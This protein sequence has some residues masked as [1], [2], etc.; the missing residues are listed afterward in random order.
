MSICLNADVRRIFQLLTVAE[1][2]ETWM[3]FPGG[4][5]DAQVTAFRHQDEYR[6][7]Y[8]CDGRQH[9]SISGSYRVCRQRKVLFSW[10][11]PGLSS[12]VSLVDIRLRGNFGSSI[13]E[14]RHTGLSSAVEYFW[15]MAMWRASL[16]RLVRLTK[17]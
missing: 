4:E 17:N 2:L 10:S 5:P 6:L 16:E 14:L 13:L 3:C 15:Q 11:N 12:G 8:L 1:Y 9:T 7:E